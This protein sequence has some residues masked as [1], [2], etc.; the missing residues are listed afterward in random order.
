M[1]SD[2]RVEQIAVERPEPCKGA[3][4]VGAGE[5]AVSSYIRRKNGREFT[6]LRH[7]S[8]SIAEE[9]STAHPL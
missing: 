5:L 3:L 9:G 2:G 1:Q 7:G 6:S 8:P 4:L